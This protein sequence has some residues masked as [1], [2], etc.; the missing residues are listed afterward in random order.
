[1]GQAVAAGIS[2]TSPTIAGPGLPPHWH[3]LAPG[4]CTDGGGG[5]LVRLPT[6]GKTPTS[7]AALAGHRRGEGTSQACILRRQRPVG[8]HT[9]SGLRGVNLAPGGGEGGGG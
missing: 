4:T 5:V 3:F 8:L 9:A 2:P 1:M 7:R 6:L